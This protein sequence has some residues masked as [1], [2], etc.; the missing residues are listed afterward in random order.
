MNDKDAKSSSGTTAIVIVVAVL[1][2]GIPCI[3]G[4]LA[5]FGVGFF[6][7]RTGASAPDQPPPQVMSQPVEPIM[8]EP[9]PVKPAPETTA[10]PEAAAPSESTAPAPSED[11]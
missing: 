9:L 6:F 10:P 4:V 3:A 8:T 2:L 1:I 11:K 7:V 5:V